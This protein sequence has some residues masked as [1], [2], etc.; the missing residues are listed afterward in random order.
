MR[1]GLVRGTGQ[2]T[3]LNAMAMGK[4]VVVSDVAGA[5]GYVENGRTGLIVDGSAEGYVRALR[6]LLSSEA[7]SSDMGARARTAVREHYTYRVHVDRLLEILD[8]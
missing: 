5:R 3:Y 7:E 8:E 6:R 4:P 2:Q 1:A